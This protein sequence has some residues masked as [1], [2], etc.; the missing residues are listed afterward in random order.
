MY[1]EPRRSDWLTR[2]LLHPKMLTSLH[3]WK[4]LLVSFKRFR[5]DLIRNALFSSVPNIERHCCRWTC[6][7]SAVRQLNDPLTHMSLSQAQMFAFSTAA[8]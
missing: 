5:A 4:Y 6:G 7:T 2:S 3:V 8:S 1:G